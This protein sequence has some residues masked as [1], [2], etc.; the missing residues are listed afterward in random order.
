MFRQSR[1][2]WAGRPAGRPTLCRGPRILQR[3][4]ATGALHVRAAQARGSP[5]RALILPTSQPTP[6]CISARAWPFLSSR[7]R[8]TDVLTIPSVT[9]RTGV[10]GANWRSVSIGGLSTGAG[11]AIS[12]PHPTRTA[13]RSRRGT[14]T[15]MTS[16]LPGSGPGSAMPGRRARL[17]GRSRLRHTQ[18][19]LEAPP[20]P[21]SCE[22]SF[23]AGEEQEARMNRAAFYL[24]C[25]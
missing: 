14:V 13:A 22:P 5:E 12:Q 7:A 1:G 6:P 16:C 4:R 15:V 17:A 25:L 3:P 19:H 2:P 24:P 21:A 8:K 11:C 9:R 10:P 20:T 23:L 18:A